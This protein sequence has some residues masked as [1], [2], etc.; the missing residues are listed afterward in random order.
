MNSII[1][2]YLSDIQIKKTHLFLP[3][4]AM[5]LI[6]A[7]IGTNIFAQRLVDF[8]FLGV[9]FTVGGGIFLFP[10]ILFWYMM[11]ISHL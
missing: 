8:N 3:I 10:I 6:T 4:F 9:N 2:R 5:L 7:N 11:H 1:N